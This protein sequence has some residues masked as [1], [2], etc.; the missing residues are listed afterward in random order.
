VSLRLV[1]GVLRRELSVAAGC[2]I[3]CRRRSSHQRG[4]LTPRGESVPLWHRIGK[5]R[6]PPGLNAGARNDSPCRSEPRSY[7]DFFRFSQVLLSSGNQQLSGARV[8]V[9]CR[10]GWQHGSGLAA[11]SCRQAPAGLR[12]WPANRCSWASQVGGTELPAGCVRR[13]NVS[14]AP[15]VFRAHST[16]GAG[17]I[18][19]P[20]PAGAHPARGKGQQG[21]ESNQL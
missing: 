18:L 14:T 11:T 3:G 17:A 2:I 16:P 8:D 7:F 20:S 4:T 10:R 15:S 19:R 1:H 21:L 12:P 9:S 5:T 13:G 6:A